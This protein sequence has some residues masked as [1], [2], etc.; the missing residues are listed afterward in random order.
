MANKIPLIAA[1]VLALL[2][3]ARIATA[4]QYHGTVLD[5]DTGEPIQGAAV[6]I[7]WYK[8]AL[9][10]FPGDA[11]EHLQAVKETVTDSAGRFAVST[12][13]GI[14]WNPSTHVKPPIIVIYKPGYEPLAPGFT[15]RRAF[16][17]IEDFERQLRRGTTIRLPK[18]KP[19]CVREHALVMGVEELL[20]HDV[21]AARIPRLLRLISS[22]RERCGLEPLRHL[23]EGEQ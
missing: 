18:L 2:P 13:R 10:A 12:W 16:H 9:F 8:T 11:P 21:P 17:S 5:A 22:Q 14:D 7:V 6:V 1:L 23:P 3:G 15:P 19:E 4:S 20:I